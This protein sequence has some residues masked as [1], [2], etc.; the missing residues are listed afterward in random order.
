[1]RRSIWLQLIKL[2]PSCNRHKP[3]ASLCLNCC[4][5]LL[6]MRPRNA[7]LF[8][9]GGPLTIGTAATRLDPSCIGQVF[10]SDTQTQTG[11]QIGIARIAFPCGS[12]VSLCQCVAAAA[13]CSCSLSVNCFGTKLAPCNEFGLDPEKVRVFSQWARRAT[14]L[15]KA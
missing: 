15:S 6:I 8:Y 5:T 10:A 1:M 9:F 3:L 12:I 7:N 2:A 13:N 14:C 11:Q 4:P